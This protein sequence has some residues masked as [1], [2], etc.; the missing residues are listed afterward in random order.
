MVAF[1]PH[2]YT[3]TRDLWDDFTAAFNDADV[4]LVTEIY[5]AGEPKLPGIETAELVEAIRAHG[6]RD[7]HF[8]R[9]LEELP[10]RVARIARSGDL[11]MTLGAGSIATA[12]RRILAA[13]E[14]AL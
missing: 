4:L 14:G 13:L 3:R 11:V 12:G 6:P 8:V 1:Q 9:N 10:E 7:A 5:A 2:R